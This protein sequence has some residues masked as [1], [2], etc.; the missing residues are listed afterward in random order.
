VIDL[1]D[2][3]IQAE[4]E[5]KGKWVQLREAAL[6]HGGNTVEMRNLLVLTVPTWVSVFQA[7]LYIEKE[8]IPAVKRDVIDQGCLLAG[9]DKSLF[10]ELERSRREKRSMT[11]NTASRLLKELLVQVDQLARHVDKKLF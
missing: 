3:R 7:L 2:L 1:A 10:L 4:R 5:I 6:E 11:R 8:E 9:L